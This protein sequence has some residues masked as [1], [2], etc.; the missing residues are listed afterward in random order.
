[1]YQYRIYTE[2][3]NVKW[4]CQIVSEKFPG[5]TIYKAKGF[6]QSK[7]EKSL[8]IEIIVENLARNEHYI[9]QICLKIKGYNKQESVLLTKQE[10]EIL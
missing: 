2:R 8:I 9:R 10:I 3:K 4:I 5:F 1:M 7:P 6:W